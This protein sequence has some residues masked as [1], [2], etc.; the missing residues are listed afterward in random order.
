MVTMRDVAKRAGVTAQTVSNV[1]NG[2]DRS[3]FVTA[4]TREK[5]LRAVTELDYHPN[6]TA[7]G[8][9]NR[10]THTLGFV[11]VD[12]SS[13]FLSDL[14]HS[15]VASGIAGAVRQRDHWLL[16]HS[17]AP[18][19]HTAARL[20][21]PYLQRRID[22]A[23]V[24]LSG[25]PPLR[26]TCVQRLVDSACPFVLL[27]DHVACPHGASVRGD[28]TDGARQA[29]SH[30]QHQGHQRIAFLAGATVWPAVEQ[31]I[32]GYVRAMDDAG[33][34]PCVFQSHVSHGGTDQEWT[35]HTGQALGAAL[36][37]AHPDVSAIVA[38]NDVL[39][40]G[41][42]QAVKAQGRR[43]PDDVA[44]IGFDDF[45]FAAYVDPALT[46]VKLD[47]Y[48]MGQRAAELLLSYDADHGFPDKEVVLPATL[49][50]RA[51]A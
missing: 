37:A 30:L 11:V 45:E 29:V 47:G 18:D 32:D 43:V 10:R 44:I 42:M 24:T 33:M 12:T 27:E 34:A 17:L 40:A 41:A 3:P 48:A 6:S 15:E 28:N 39:A 50:A 14:F 26:H 20:L 21:E 8:L 46:S 7:R 2:R 22:G 31:R 25:P 38:A 23:V 19:E 13:A 1:L 9:R 4:Q 51:S 35:I 5:I 49:I 36:L 16:I